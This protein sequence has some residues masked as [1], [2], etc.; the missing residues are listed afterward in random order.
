VGFIYIRGFDNEKGFFLFK[1]GLDSLIK[2][3]YYYFVLE[4]GLGKNDKNV[5]A[6][7]FF[8]D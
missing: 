1:R 7:Y 2:E 3:S 5:F 8:F 4:E 6:I